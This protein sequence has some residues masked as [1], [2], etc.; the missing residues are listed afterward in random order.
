MVKLIILKNG[1]MAKNPEGFE[2]Q[3]L[4]KAVVLEDS[5]FLSKHDIKKIHISDSIF[6]YIA[7]LSNSGYTFQQN[8]ITKGGEYIWN[9]LKWKK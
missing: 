5:N 2:A 9:L 8:A 6:E 3:E 1:E 7:T 4:E